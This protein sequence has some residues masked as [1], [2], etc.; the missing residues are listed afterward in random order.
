MRW[1]DERLWGRL[2]LAVIAGLMAMFCL[3]GCK[4]TKYVPMEKVV[5]R[6]SVRHDTLH[7]RD[8]IYVHDSVST[9]QKGDTI[10]RDRWHR[11]TILKE[12]LKSKTDSFIKRDSITVPYPVEKELSKWERFQLKYALWSMGATCAL[13]VVLG[14]IIYRRIKNARNQTGNK[15]G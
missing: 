14:I 2:V 9:S 7:K 12:V 8:S 3:V 15:Q 4:T 10:F 1:Y 6:E 11:E 5:C 13:L